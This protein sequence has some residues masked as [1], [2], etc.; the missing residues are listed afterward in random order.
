MEVEVRG[1]SGREEDECEVVGEVDRGQNTSSCACKGVFKYQ[2][3]GIS[4]SN[5][6]IGISNSLGHRIE[7]GVPC[8]A[9][10][11]SKCSL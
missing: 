5:P 9:A 7:I 11:S 2:F 10:K 6:T 8:W 1:M 3:P 4:G